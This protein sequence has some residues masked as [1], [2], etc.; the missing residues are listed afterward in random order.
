MVISIGENTKEAMKTLE[1]KEFPFSNK[2]LRK[3]FAILLNT[4]H[5]D[6]NNGAGDKNKTR[7]IIEAY[8]ILK[9]LAS[10][11]INIDE[12]KKKMKSDD[13]FSLWERCSFCSG[14]VWK[15]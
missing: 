15:S 12:P 8:N 9:N 5:P 3:N 14:S 10:E 2:L 1:I 7:E 6:K 11:N 13:L 4:Y